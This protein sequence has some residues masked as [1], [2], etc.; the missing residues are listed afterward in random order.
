MAG[1][2]RDSKKLAPRFYLNYRKVVAAHWGKVCFSTLTKMQ[3]LNFSIKKWEY[4]VDKMR[5][6]R[7]VV[8]SDGGKQTCALCM[9]YIEDDCWACPIRE[10][11]GRKWCEDTPYASNMGILSLKR[12]KNEVNFLKSLKP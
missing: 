10:E 1:K 8:I 6:S 2:K 12:A 7:T 11:T 4:I 9:K 5:D 3:A